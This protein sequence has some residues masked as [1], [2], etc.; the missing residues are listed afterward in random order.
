MLFH[1][2][3]IWRL[4]ELGLLPALDCISSTSGGTVLAARLAARWD[5][6]TFRN[7]AATNFKQEIAWPICEI[8]SRTLAAPWQIE[9]LFRKGFVPRKLSN[10]L[11]WVT[12]GCFVRDL[13]PKPKFVFKAACFE[14]G[15]V[16]AFSNSLEAVHAAEG[17]L[18]S[19]TFVDPRLGL[20]E[21]TAACIAAPPL[22]PVRFG[23]LGRKITW[24]EGAGDHPTSIAL[25]DGSLD[26]NFGVDLS[27]DRTLLISDGGFRFD[28]QDHRGLHWLNPEFPLVNWT[29]EKIHRL[30]KDALK[31]RLD[32]NNNPIY[33]DIEGFIEQFQAPS[34]LDCDREVTRTVAAARSNLSGIE[35]PLQDALI[36]W[37]YALADA[38][39]RSRISECVSVRP[40]TASPKGVFYCQPK[41]STAGAA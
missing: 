23:G 34:V 24:P 12:E 19:R 18:A 13:Q 31:D 4:N 32:C 40:P 11:K 15:E 9:A 22:P 17:D 16:W 1:L 38:A 36:D 6:L 33:W 20:W 41:R 30:R 8:A 7:D 2:G 39:M 10:A 29:A 25:F 21:I 26:D 27:A 37:G 5:S 28:D 35:E 3:G 14:T